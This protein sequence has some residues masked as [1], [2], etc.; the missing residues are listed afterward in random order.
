MLFGLTFEKV[1]II[2]VIAAFLIGPDKL[3]AAA[4]GLGRLVRQLKEMAS[5]AKERL[6]EDMGEE[7]TEIGWQQLDPRQYDPRRII[8]EALVDDV[9]SAA[10]AAGGAG[11]GIAAA[12]QA[13]V[14]AAAVERQRAVLA[15]EVVPV[16]PFD[17]EAT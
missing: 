11:S 17:D 2:G 9:P 8:R 7:Y 1:I 10:A 5:G 4:A 13:R 16:A 12:A 3:P 6:K 15:G 14:S